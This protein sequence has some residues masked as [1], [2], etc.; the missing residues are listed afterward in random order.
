MPA[1]VTILILFPPFPLRNII[2]MPVIPDHMLSPVWHM[3]THGGQ[4]L[5]G[6]KMIIEG[7][8]YPA[9]FGSGKFHLHGMGTHI[10]LPRRQEYC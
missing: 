10:R 1:T 5:Q 3:G 2:I 8:I 7:S 9:R 4:P 6:V